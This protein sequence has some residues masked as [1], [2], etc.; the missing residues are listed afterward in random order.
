MSISCLPTSFLLPHFS[1]T[2]VMSFYS[3]KIQAYPHLKVFLLSVSS[4]RSSIFPDKIPVN[5][6]P[7]F[8]FCSKPLSYESFLSTLIKVDSQTPHLPSYIFFYNVFHHLTLQI[9]YFIV[10]FCV[11]LS[12]HTKI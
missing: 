11:C 6:L 3:S 10:Y 5:S 4:C 2:T 9:F 12:S 1:I 7:S 8:S